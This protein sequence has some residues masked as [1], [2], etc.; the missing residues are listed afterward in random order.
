MYGIKRTA[1][2]SLCYLLERFPCVAVI[3]ARQV[4]KTTLLKQA[5]PDAPFF[6][7]E[8]RLD[9]ERIHHDP[10]FFLSQ[11]K[12][13]IV[14]DEAQTLPELFPALRVAIDEH[15]DQNG[16]FLISGSSSPRLLSGLTES[17]AGR[18]ALFE[19]NGLSLEEQW[20]AP[21]SMFYHYIGEGNLEGL[22]SLKPRFSTDQL[23]MSWFFGSYPEPFIKFRNE[24]KAF[25]VWMEN[26]FQTYIQRDVRTLFPGLNLTAYQ[27]FTGMLA[28]SSSQILNVSEFARSL[29][30]SQPT[31]KSYFDIADGTFVW[32]ML[33]SYQK[34][35]S[36]RVT[37]MP[38]G[39]MRDTG[40]LNHLLALPSIDRLQSHPSSGHIWETFVIEQ[41]IKSLAN[42]M[43]LVH[44]YYYRTN[45]MAEIDLILE[46]PA[47]VVPIEIK[48][49]GTPYS[50]QL[51]TLETFVK[52]HK[53][54]FG[55]LINNSTETT[56]LTKSILQIPASCL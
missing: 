19:L 41:I 32:R 46:T 10:D 3:G 43:V 52:E 36:K 47:G 33:P 30:V 25:G 5:L 29:D 4:G 39:H 2:S 20:G 26:Y 6:D 18:I 35:T 28:A 49:G 27:R 38:K 13:P 17:L 54:R 24:S 55:I 56:W 31:A 21:L 53:L 40:L 37:K 23:F 44:P 11:H 50:R 7:L 45:N 16:R 12:K 1:V 51:Q 22:A 48:L 14:I 8:K 15:R 9:F 42:T 34:S